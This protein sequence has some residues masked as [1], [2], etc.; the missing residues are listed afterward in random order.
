MTKSW[1]EPTCACHLRERPL[2]DSV[3]EEQMWYGTAKD[4]CPGRRWDFAVH[5]PL[6]EA[7][8]GGP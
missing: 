1:I 2:N 5:D 4:V 7:S 8:E 6:P 3:D